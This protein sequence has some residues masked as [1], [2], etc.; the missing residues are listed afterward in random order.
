MPTVYNLSQKL[1]QLY[2]VYENT[3]NVLLVLQNEIYYYVDGGKVESSNWLRYINCSRKRSEE[4]VME[5]QCYDKPYYMTRKDIY[6][7]Q[8]LLVYY[9]DNYAEDLDIDTEAYLS[10]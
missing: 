8:E 5:I 7:G 3:Y 9:G 1:N 2:A 4:N 10:Y 6:P